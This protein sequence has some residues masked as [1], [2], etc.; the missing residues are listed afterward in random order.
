M[1]QDFCATLQIARR[2][3]DDREIFDRCLYPI[4]N[5][6]AKIL[7]EGIA[8]RASD[9]DVALQFGYGWPVYRG[10]PMFEADRLGLPE[11]LRRLRELEA[12]HGDRFK[13]ASLIESLAESGQ[14]FRDVRPATRQSA[15]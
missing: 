10:G 7:Q 12:E 15:A 3:I 5:E 11:V 14:G 4:I 8:L 13:P 9:I 6:G 1:I 2:S